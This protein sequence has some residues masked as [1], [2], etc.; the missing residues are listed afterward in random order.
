MESVSSEL[1]PLDLPSAADHMDA[2]FSVFS[3]LPADF[4]SFTPSQL[5]D[6]NQQFLSD[7]VPERP[8][9]DDVRPMSSLRSEYEN[10]SAT[11]LKQIDWLI[12]QGFGHVRRARGDGDCFYRS[13]GF[14]Y[15]ES[16]INSSE[17]D[18]AV[19][20]SLSILES[21]KETLDSAGIQKMV[22][23][24][25]YDDFE[26]LIQSITKPDKHGRTLNTERLLSAFQKPEVSNSIVIYLR[27]LTSAQIRLN[28][29]S[30]EG[31]LVHPDTK[32][33]M[34]VDSFCDN[35]VQAMGKEAD[36]VEIEALCRALQLN[37]DLAYLN[38]VR[39]DAV[40]FIKFRYHS[41]PDVTP[42]V[43][44]YRP[45]HYDILIHKPL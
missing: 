6:M 36:N 35:V 44:L 38:G 16:L 45:G 11:F 3:T 18:F 30:Y 34:D 7:A 33:P 5:Y 15:V 26:A 13:L 24:D 20:S 40:D 43:L 9:I 21:T 4:S 8:L 41:N 22:Y 37:V 27:F 31:F 14:A 19:G 32:D 25:F 29:D 1:P 28:R 42:V 17:R 10:G 12:K 23:E 2:S 39:G